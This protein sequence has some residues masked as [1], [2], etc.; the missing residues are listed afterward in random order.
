MAYQR[1]SLYQA[2]QTD[3]PYLVLETENEQIRVLRMT[4]EER[5]IR[6]QRLLRED[7]DRFITE[8]VGVYRVFLALSKSCR[9]EPITNKF[10]KA[11]LAPSASAAV[12]KFVAGQTFSQR[13]I[14]L[15]VHN[16]LM[17]LL[18]LLTNFHT[19]LLPGRWV[20]CKDRIHSYF[21]VIYD[22]KVLASEYCTE[23][24]SRTHLHGVYETTLE[25]YP[26]W[27]HQDG[28]ENF[29]EEPHD[30]AYNAYM[31][32]VSFCG[33]SQTIND[34][35]KI[36]SSSS[37]ARFGLWKVP[38][39]EDFPRRIYGRNKIHFPM[40]PYTIDLETPCDPLGKGM[41]ELSTYRVSNIDSQ[42][43]TRDIL[44]CV[45]GLTD[46]RHRAV[47]IELFW[48][49]DTTFLVGARITDLKQEGELFKEHGKILL[50]ALE[51]RFCNGEEI[52]K[53]VSS[54]NREMTKTVWNL[55]G[56][57]RSDKSGRGERPKK[58]GRFE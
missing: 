22:T 49:D 26:E 11:I 15:I 42:V 41:S 14:P 8:N 18:F 7:Y 54:S 29:E 10:E 46:S 58:R 25:N 37:N 30:T 53:L 57:L 27:R 55:W 12:A 9:G 34:H 24:M 28:S 52:R 32:G 1:R 39:C 13:K 38:D 6:N 20:D 4:D 40:S 51:E 16:G 50:Q 56:L 17:D 2:I 19:S 21:P 5:T 44:D 48:V 47:N 45:R 43:T 36:P 33:L 35:C 3:Y 23:H 31:T